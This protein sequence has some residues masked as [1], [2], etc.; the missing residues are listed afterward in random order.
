MFFFSKPNILLACDV[1]F[2][3]TVV[4]SDDTNSTKRTVVTVPTNSIENFP[5]DINAVC[6][7]QFKGGPDLI[8][9]RRSFKY[10][11][12]KRTRN[13]SSQYWAWCTVQFKQTIDGK[14][15]ESIAWPMLGS[16]LVSCFA[17]PNYNGHFN[18]KKILQI[19]R[20]YNEANPN[21]PLVSIKPTENKPNEKSVKNYATLYPEPTVVAI[22]EQNPNM[23]DL[24]HYKM[25]CAKFE[26]EVRYA[27]GDVCLPMYFKDAGNLVSNYN[28]SWFAQTLAKQKTEDSVETP[29]ETPIETPVETATVQTGTE[30]EF[31]QERVVYCIRYADEPTK[32]RIG[33]VTSRPFNK[34]LEEHI[35]YTNKIPI[36]VFAFEQK[37]GHHKIHPQQFEHDMQMAVMRDLIASGRIVNDDTSKTLLSIVQC[38]DHGFTWMDSE[39]DLTRVCLTETNPFFSDHFDLLNT[40]D[41][42]GGNKALQ[43]CTVAKNVKVVKSDKSPSSS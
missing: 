6:F 36:V 4:N 42:R 21:N 3:S 5:D 41:I 19:V 23:F 27:F 14:S 2:Y 20:D 11:F 22:L 38:G 15:Y 24:E 13:A 32:Y 12:R 10:N 1:R 17:L 16:T 40:T 34:R 28:D 29:V 37:S 7:E 25:F 43:S 18:G 31:F 9:R 30:I 26:T 8:V 39:A 35:K 33:N